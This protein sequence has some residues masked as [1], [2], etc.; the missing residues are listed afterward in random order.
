[1]NKKTFNKLGLD[2]YSETLDN[3]LSIYVVPM[4]N[5]HNIY[6]SLN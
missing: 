4:L 1:M 6:S 2:V 5:K 3:G